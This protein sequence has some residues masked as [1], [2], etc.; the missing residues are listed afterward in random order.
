MQ[1]PV[2]VLPPERLAMSIPVI[3]LVHLRSR[4]VA[5]SLS[6]NRM[7]AVVRA[8]LTARRGLFMQANTGKFNVIFMKF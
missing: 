5:L 7:P 8:S 4:E 6:R 1:L 3:F 2:E